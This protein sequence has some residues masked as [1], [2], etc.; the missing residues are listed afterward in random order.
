[1]SDYIGAGPPKGTG[2]HRYVF[3]VYK[4]PG[5]VEFKVPKLT[6]TSTDGRPNF[7]VRAFAAD[8]SLGSPVA[9][10]CFQAEWDDYVPKLY[11]QFK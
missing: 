10:N 11:A 2:L 3:V 6:N 7:K 4:Q 9:G 5:V 8:H 1:M